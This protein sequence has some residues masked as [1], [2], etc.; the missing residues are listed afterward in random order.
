MTPEEKLQQQA[1]IARASTQF[2]RVNQSLKSSSSATVLGFN[3]RLGMYRIQLADGSVHYA[4]SNTNGV[5]GIGDVVELHMSGGT[6]SI[7]APTVWVPKPSVSPRRIPPTVYPFKVLFSVVDSSSGMRKFYMGGS[8]SPPKLITET[9]HPVEYAVISNTGIRPSE[10]VAG[11]RAIDTSSDNDP[12][13][14]YVKI[15]QSIGKEHEWQFTT[16]QASLLVYKGHGVWVTPVTLPH[17]DKTLTQDYTYISSNPP[18]KERKYNFY[19][20]YPGYLTATGQILQRVTEGASPRFEETRNFSADTF[21]LLRYKD[22]ESNWNGVYSSSYSA[23]FTPTGSGGSLYLPRRYGTTGS[24][25]DD[26]ESDRV[27]SVS[28]TVFLSP[29]VSGNYSFTLGLS[30][31]SGRTV[32][33][34]NGV[35]T[36]DERNF[37]DRVTRTTDY[38]STVCT[39]LG[40]ETCITRKLHHRRDDQQSGYWNALSGYQTATGSYTQEFSSSYFFNDKDNSSIEINNAISLLLNSPIQLSIN[41][42]TTSITIASENLFILPEN[43]LNGGSYNSK[44]YQELLD[45]TQANDTTIQ[46]TGNFM[47]HPLIN[48]LIG[49]PV[50]VSQVAADGKYWTVYGT[51]SDYNYTTREETIYHKANYYH[52]KTNRTLRIISELE[53]N[54]SSVTQPLFDSFATENGCLHSDNTSILPLIFRHIVPNWQNIN[55]P[56]HATDPD[57]IRSL[58][59]V[60]VSAFTEENLVANNLNLIGNKIYIASSINLENSRNYAEAWEIDSEGKLKKIKVVTGDFYPIRGS[61]YTIHS[62]SY[63]PPR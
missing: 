44:N 10:F 15:T 57:I 33:V 45:S 50:I 18:I 17:V 28:S 38:D 6:Y 43:I 35:T 31:S 41:E 7:D 49:L 56:L 4:V 32:T 34:S 54:V 19:G 30:S 2:R 21:Q 27:R 26:I 25:I 20:S 22:S 59:S 52:Y 16:P 11:I 24:E 5:I 60:D 51:L 62:V 40:G 61:N 9:I 23:S 48:S 42:N 39:G 53:I 55:Y 29:L 3:A 14:G 13:L 1:L 12:Y 47:P 36:R 58:S 37:S 63:Y 46:Y 8:D